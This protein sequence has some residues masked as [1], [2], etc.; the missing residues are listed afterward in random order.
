MRYL[1]TFLLSLVLLCG[2]S[3][4][5]QQKLDNGETP[6]QL[7]AS[8]VTQDSLYGKHYQGGL[9]FHFFEDST[10][11]LFGTKDLAY[12][13]DTSKT[14]II[15]SCRVITTG[16]TDTKIG[17]GK[18]NTRKIKAKNCPLYDP[19][20]KKWMIPAAEICLLYSG[21]GNHDWFLPSKDEL[22][23]A[24]MKLSYTGY[25][26]FDDKEYWT[27]SERDDT[28][29]WVEHF[30]GPRVYE[31]FGQSFYK[32]FYKESVRPVRYFTN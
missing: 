7:M 14:K 30:P 12:D 11:M 15:W 20:A 25:H 9:I 23:E 29:A 26:D 21:G 18:E 17:S 32:K 13:Y 4:S 6:K 2:K 16:A 19:D 5:I 8:G 31:M 22:H 3:Q 28:F 10:G 1:C 24:Y 27:S